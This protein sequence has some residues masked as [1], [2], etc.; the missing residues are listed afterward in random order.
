LR[1]AGISLQVRLRSADFNDG[2][3][4]EVRTTLNASR[5]AIY[6]FTTLDRYYKGM[7]LRVTSPYDAMAGVANL[8][9]VGEVVRVQR[10]EGGYGVAV[11]LSTCGQ[12]TPVNAP[13]VRAAAPPAEL[14]A[15]ES[16]NRSQSERRGAA[17]SPFVTPAELVDMR[18]G[19]RTAARTS[20][21][22]MEGCYIDTLNPLPVGAA[23]RV[24]MQRHGQVL[25][26]L[27]NV[28]SRH[29]GSGMGL[30]FAD[31][32]P[33]QRDVV[34]T[35]L[36]ELRLPPRMNFTEAFPASPQ[37]ARGDQAY[38]L[39]LI[40]MLL[41]KGLLSQSEANEILSDPDA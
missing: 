18:T 25:D 2:N 21:L 13:L 12:S 41:R 26:V 17:R 28:S 20:D 19:S 35:W 39:R 37:P 15:L 11:T 9:Q 33:A 5:K 7:R 30:V 32:T 22:S 16:R 36:S 31:M 8:E 27:A 38:T 4:E 3:F 10:R 24:Q 23:V 34:S 14:L 6:F 1:R 29:A 40:Q